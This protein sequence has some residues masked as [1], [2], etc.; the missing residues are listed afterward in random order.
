MLEILIWIC[1][2]EQ[3][4]RRYGC[5]LGNKVYTGGGRHNMDYLKARKGPLV[6]NLNLETTVQILY[7]FIPL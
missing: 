7:T 2:P 6:F 3:N 5:Y 4:E 1:M